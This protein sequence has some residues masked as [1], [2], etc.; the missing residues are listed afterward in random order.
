V[1]REEDEKYLIGLEKK[2]VEKDVK[3]IINQWELIRANLDFKERIRKV[4]VDKIKED[5]NL[6]D[7]VRT[8]K[9]DD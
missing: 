2:N 4:N 3:D 9:R 7:E 1:N 5:F 8:M 6:M